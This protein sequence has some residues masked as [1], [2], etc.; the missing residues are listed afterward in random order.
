MV[1]IARF[2]RIDHK[3][4]LN[5]HTQHTPNPFAQLPEATPPRKKIVS[6]LIQRRLRGLCLI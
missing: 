2:V 5:L 3:F 1:I 6:N 4:K